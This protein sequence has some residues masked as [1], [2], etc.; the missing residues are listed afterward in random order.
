MK[1]DLLQ[2]LKADRDAETRRSVRLTE[3]ADRC[4]AYTVAQ[5]LR[6]QAEAH[7]A[8]AA[9]ITGLIEWVNDYA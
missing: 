4:N 6:N 9:Y 2:R 8:K 7:A 5:P 3:S 1:A